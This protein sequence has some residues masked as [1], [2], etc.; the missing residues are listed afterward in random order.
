MLPPNPTTTQ[1]QENVK[2]NQALEL[3]RKQYSKTTKYQQE[4]EYNPTHQPKKYA[5]NYRKKESS[6]TELTE[7]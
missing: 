5:A 6:T 1:K 7:K 3:C 4:D 2:P